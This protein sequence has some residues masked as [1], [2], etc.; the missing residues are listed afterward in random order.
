MTSGLPF[1]DFRNLLT[2]LEGRDE[3]A[4]AGV[5]SLYERTGKPK[6]SLGRLEDIAEWLAAWTG[7][8]PP[9]VN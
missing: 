1:D 8:V 5:R 2:D 7:R 3:R 9:V 6:G 4:A